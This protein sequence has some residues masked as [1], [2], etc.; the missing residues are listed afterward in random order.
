M[1]QVNFEEF[2][3]ELTRRLKE[4]LGENLV[5]LAFFGS[6][7]RGEAREE[8]DI[9]LL[10][11]ARELPLNPI[12]RGKVVYK[13]I[14]DMA[15][16][17]RISILARTVE[18][19]TADVTPLHLDLSEDAV[20][21]YDP[22]GFLESRLKRVR[23][24]IEEAGLERRRNSQGILYW[25]WKGPPPEPGW[26]LTWEGFKGCFPERMPSSG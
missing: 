3:R 20:I 17:G 12:E 4:G 7:A 1:E 9:D 19:F 26:S 18:E 5:A 8:S 10:L 6:W 11:I 2:A 22:E 13:P 14:E 25:W 23:E 15:G 24:L 21:I 16:Q